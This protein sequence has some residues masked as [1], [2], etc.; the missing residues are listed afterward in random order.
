LIITPWALL[1]VPAA[2]LV[3]FGFASIGMG[4]TTYLKSFHEMNWVNFFL[5]PMFLFSGTFY[6]ISVFPTALQAVIQAFPLW[7]A[8]DLIR[9]LMLGQI[10]S[11]LIGNVIYFAVMVMIGLVLTTRRLTALFMR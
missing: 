2:V 11:G 1:A 10:D 6:P 5:L 8:V 7:Q 9:S 4:I 3:A